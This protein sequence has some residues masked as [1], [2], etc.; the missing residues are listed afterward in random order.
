MIAAVITLLYWPTMVAQSSLTAE[1]KPAFDVVS[2]KPNES[3]SF[4]WSSS[5]VQDKVGRY[6]AINAPLSALIADY[7]GLK[8]ES[9]IS[10][11]PQWLGTQR[12]DI[13]AQV[14]GEPGRQTLILMVQSLI[15]N[16]F[17]LQF[18][19]ESRMASVNVLLGPKNGVAY[20]S[21]LANA[22][23]R[24]CPKGPANAL[25]CRPVVSSPRGMAMEHVNT[26]VVAQTFSAMLHQV[27][28]DESGLTGRY[29]ITLD[30]DLTP[31]QSG[32]PVVFPEIIA[33]ALR[34]Q[35]GFRLETQKRPLDMLVIDHVE[36]PSAN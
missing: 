8:S 6:R 18:H 25:G 14:D 1:R 5:G 4:P 28:I 27:V 21:H 2:I 19:R 23:D 29:D 20:G 13:Q 34:M 32:A 26:A 15:E 7:F 35:T 11:G 30:Y 3:G 24:D 22:D 36:R 33:D 12:F 10:G 17:Q 9:Q 31:P 16:R